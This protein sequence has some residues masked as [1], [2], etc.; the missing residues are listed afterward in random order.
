MKYVYWWDK[1]GWCPWVKMAHLDIGAAISAAISLNLER[2][3]SA[4][5]LYQCHVSPLHY[6]VG[7]LPRK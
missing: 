6:H 1:R 7:K 5:H 3:D 4:C 2:N